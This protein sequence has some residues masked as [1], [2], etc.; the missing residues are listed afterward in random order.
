[1]IKIKFAFFFFLAYSLYAVNPDQY[2]TD[3]I[4][5][6]FSS[7]LSR[8]FFQQVTYLGDGRTVLILSS[9]LTLLPDSNLNNLGKLSLTGYAL[10]GVATGLLKYNINRTRPNGNEHSF[11]SGH[12]STAFCCAYIISR[13]YPQWTI[14][15]YSIAG[16]VGVSRIA[17]N[18]HY[19][20]DVLGGVLIGVI[21]GWIVEKYSDIIISL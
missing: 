6:Q 7:P 10:S 12:T 20:G 13:H 17:L 21:S 11:P 14:P 8:D 18:Q 15:S 1:M 2:L 9:S 19:L 5:Q 16:A 3:K 4:N